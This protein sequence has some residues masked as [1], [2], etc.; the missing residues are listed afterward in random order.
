MEAGVLLG[1]ELM[2]LPQSLMVGISFQLSA[3]HLVPGDNFPSQDL[4]LHQTTF[5]DQVVHGSQQQLQHTAS[6]VQTA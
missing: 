2:S 6:Q 5:T 3:S 1:A 4:R